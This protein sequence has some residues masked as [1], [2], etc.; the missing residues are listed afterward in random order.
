VPL[1]A[2]GLALIQRFMGAAAAYRPRNPEENPLYGLV[3]RHLET[4]LSRQR[5][6]DRHVPGFVECEF[7]AFLDCGVL[8]RGWRAAFGG[9]AG[10]RVTRTGDRIDPET[11]GALASSRCA[12]VAGFSL[13][14][15]VAVHAG[16]RQRL[17]RLL[18]YCARPAI[19]MER[20]ELLPEG[21]IRYQLKRAWRDGSTHILMEPQELLEK[22]A[23]LVPFPRA[24]LVR[25]AGLLAPAAKWRAWIV[26]AELSDST[27][28]PSSSAPCSPAKSSQ[29]PGVSAEPME[30]A[31]YHGRNYTWAELM[32]RA[33][34]VDVLE[35]PRCKGRM[36]ILA[37]IPLARRDPKNTRLSRL[38]IPR[39]AR[40]AGRLR[41][42]RFRRTVLNQSCLL[43]PGQDLSAPPASA[44]PNLK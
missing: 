34:A 28:S 16:D 21:R 27:A 20:L 8:S 6:R 42:S 30:S 25:Y 23:A 7:R 33:W 40:F 1:E 19:A 4:F 5:E 15:N 39:A 32:K 14:A 35:C 38:A 11:M 31:K 13:H 3:A 10:R 37:A 17:E 9:K 29:T 43:D 2:R 12:S 26:P 36:R 44:N 22:L 41:I 24:H 18:R